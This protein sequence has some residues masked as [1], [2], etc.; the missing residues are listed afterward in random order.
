MIQLHSNSLFVLPD[1][2]HT[3]ALGLPP[4]A[5]RC[6]LTP[7]MLHLLPQE[8]VRLQTEVDQKCGALF[9]AVAASE[10]EQERAQTTMALHYCVSSVVCPP[11]AAAF[12]SALEQNAQADERVIEAASSEMST[13][14]EDFFHKCRGVGLAAALED[15]PK[16]GVTLRSDVS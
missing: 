2:V 5:N 15:Q 7:L 8:T 9:G 11:A 10:D 1:H 16:Q 13:C 14:V 6:P 3:T 12:M 4:A